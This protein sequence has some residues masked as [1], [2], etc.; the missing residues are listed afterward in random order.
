M[1]N[2][3]VA[4]ITDGFPHATSGSI[5][6][7]KLYVRSVARRWQ[8]EMSSASCSPQILSPYITPA[9][10][11]TV[12]LR[13]SK[14]VCEIYTL[15]EAEVF[16]NGASSLKTLK[17][18]VENGHSVFHLPRLHAKVLLLPNQFAT[19]GSQ[20][21]TGAGTH[22]KEAS[23][24]FADEQTVKRIEALLAPWLTERIE[25]T[26]EMIEVDRV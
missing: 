10:A 7:V 8:K 16:A 26:L 17:S 2:A 19:I 15:F 25:V 11:N 20:N 1:K 5:A 21:L 3:S 18:F 24:A 22:N 9:T 13:A 12:V 14:N 6:P 23:V 4:R